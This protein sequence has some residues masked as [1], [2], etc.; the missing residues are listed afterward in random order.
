MVGIDVY[1]ALC[2]HY[3]A[4]VY[5][6]EIA[7]DRYCENPTICQFCNKIIRVRP[8]EKPSATRNK[9]FCNH[10]CAAKYNNKNRYDW[11]EVQQFHNAG[12]SRRECMKHFGFC[13]RSWTKAKQ[14]GELIAR[15]YLAL[16]PLAELR[17][18][19]SVRRRIIKDNL[20][21]YLCT[22]CGLK[23]WRGGPLSLHLDHINGIADD[24]RIENLRWLC[25]NCH[26]QSPTYA[27][28]NV[29]RHLSQVV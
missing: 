15:S 16:M 3:S 12:N 27:G 17:E 18:R 25:P 10:S 6:R 14:R 29:V 4:M 26:S 21:P 1:L 7:L 2:Y 13:S 19:G 28:R 23:E 9:K 20:M 22:E 5:R 24:H 8:K 11:N